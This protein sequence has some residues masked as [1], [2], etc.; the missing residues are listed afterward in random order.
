MTNLKETRLISFYQMYRS[1][2]AKGGKKILLTE[3]AFLALDALS[4]HWYLII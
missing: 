1:T 2:D 3:G 4:F